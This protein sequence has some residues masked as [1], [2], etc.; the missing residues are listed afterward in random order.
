M[1]DPELDKLFSSAPDIPPPMID[2]LA[3]SLPLDGVSPENFEKLCAYLL[4]AT[5]PDVA[6]VLRYGSPQQSQGGVDIAA[7][8]RSTHKKLMMECKRVR[9]ARS[10]DIRQWID[11]F[12]GRKDLKEIGTFIL[13]ITVEVERDKHIVEEWHRSV[14]RLQ[15]VGIEAK[16]WDLDQINE[17]L[18]LQPAVVERFYGA[19]CVRRFCVTATLQERWPAEYRMQTCSDSGERLV[20]ENRSVR[21]DMFTPSE[22]QP[23]V[24]GALSFARADLSGISL[25]LNGS[26]LVSWMQWTAHS[27]SIREAPFVSPLPREARFLLQT[28]TARLQIDASEVKDLQWILS[29][30]WARYIEAAQRLDDRWRV[31]RFPLMLADSHVAF[32]LFQ[33]E[34]WFW[35]AVL[36]YAAEHDFEKGSSENHIFDG[37]ASVL[38]VCVRESRAGLRPGYH[39]IAFGY[40]SQASAMSEGGV[41]LGWHPLSDLS[42]GSAGYTPEEAWDAEHS[43]A[44]LLSSLFPAVIEWVQARENRRSGWFGKLRGRLASVSSQRRANLDDVVYSMAHTAYSSSTLRLMHVGEAKQIIE[45]LQAH[46]TVYDSEVPLESELTRSVLRLVLHLLPVTETTEDVYIRTKLGVHAGTLHDGIRKQLAD[47]S[48]FTTYSSLD[49]A[50]RSLMAVLHIRP[51]L[52]AD[53]IAYASQQLMPLWRRWKED[54][55]CRVYR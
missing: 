26:T 52:Q 43:H 53:Q 42:T 38:K 28:P 7:I 22:R 24:S 27:G 8:L 33:L 40:P 10:A 16:L 35:S 48:R 47:E 6:Q 5:Y 2:P 25:A 41:I 11:R 14:T 55:V 49:M 20:L 50:L 4:K 54:C 17:L 19:Q 45:A 31:S 21:L 9:R 34:R 30:G 15:T 32:G 13:A 12:L 1:N 44:W 39:L 3:S 46:F 36:Q 29:T 37:G 51:S 18:R 23:R